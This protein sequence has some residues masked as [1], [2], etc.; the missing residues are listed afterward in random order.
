MQILGQYDICLCNQSN[1]Y[2]L[3]GIYSTI[4]QHPM[5]FDLHIRNLQWAFSNFE[6]R[7]FLQTFAGYNFK[8]AG[9]LSITSYR[10]NPKRYF[11]FH[12][13]LRIGYGDV[14]VLVQQ[15]NLF[16]HKV[17]K[18]IDSCVRGPIMTWDQTP[19]FSIYDQ[20]DRNVYP[21]IAEI[22]TFM[23]RDLVEEMRCANL[24]YGVR[25]RQFDHNGKLYEEFRPKLQS[26]K[27][28]SNPLLP[29]PARFEVLSDFCHRERKDTMFDV[30]LYSFCMDKHV[31]LL[32][33]AAMV[34]M[35][36]PEMF[37]REYPEH[38]NAADK[39][40]HFHVPNRPRLRENIPSVALMC[41]LSGV[42]HRDEAVAEALKLGDPTFMFGLAEL[43]KN[44]AEWM[45]A[46]QLDRLNW[47]VDQ[48]QL[49]EQPSANSVFGSGGCRAFP[50]NQERV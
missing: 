42:Y 19:Y 32:D 22:S 1:G 37:H 33:P 40:L 8:E 10:A 3:I 11:P 26:V 20:Q 28:C 34:H 2:V 14:V 38:Y 5:G 17:D 25:G 16:P 27:I 47:A 18:I 30:S 36:N 9:G 45:G 24:C 21:R 46:E 7:I 39:L 4:A 41:L 15:D 44:A 35:G 29:A 43:Y 49:G 50:E 13:N 12:E 6:H 31:Q 48:V 23:S